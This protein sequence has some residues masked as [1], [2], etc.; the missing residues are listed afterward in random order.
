MNLCLILVLFFPPFS[1]FRATYMANGS[2]QTRGWI[3]AV[4][5]GLC[6]SH[7]NARSEPQL[8]LN[9]SSWQ[10]RILNPLSQSRDQTYVLMDTSQIYFYWTMTGTLILVLN[11][12]INGMWGRSGCDICHPI[13]RQGWF[14]W[15]GWLG[16]C[17]LPPSPLHVRPSRSCAL[18]RR[19]RPSPIEED[20][21]SVKGIRVAAL[22][23]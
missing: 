19:G 16:G 14:G 10:C 17:P 22:P 4:A 18:G 12:C 20:R 21:S 3:R 6:H 1:L 7:N 15:S 2:S 13:D 5:T 9:H 11:T 23:C 8:W